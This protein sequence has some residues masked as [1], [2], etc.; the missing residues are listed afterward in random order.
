MSTEKALIVV[1]PSLGDRV[2]QA[3]FPSHAEALRQ[4][5]LE[6][7]GF[8][9][10]VKDP[11]D[12]VIA[13]NTASK[14]RGFLAQL[15]DSRKAV[16]EP[17][18]KAGQAIDA[19]AKKKRE[20]IETELTRIEGY[21]ADFARAERDRVARELAAAEA[22]R[23]Q[24]AEEERQKAAAAQKII[25]DLEAARKAVELEAKNATDETA[26][27]EAA[28]KLAESQAAIDEAAFAADFAEP[29]PAP[30]EI[31]VAPV[32]KAAGTS[33]KFDYDYEV[34]DIH[35]L[36][37]AYPHLVKLEPR[38]GMIRAYI[39]AGGEVDPK[40]IPGLRCFESAKVTTKAA[41]PVVKALE[42]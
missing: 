19:F 22:L 35:A 33:T 40:N 36:Y 21:L 30:V 29:A 18:F 6:E 3:L 27:A 11:A 34:T 42:A 15:E 28:R 24:Q 38:A 16:K 17:Y 13:S 32:A 12:Q 23:L 14:L 7:A 37:K 8:I 2:V 9:E 41:R 10:P 25:D 20:D 26:R 39:N 31:Y 5:C 1:E 4:E